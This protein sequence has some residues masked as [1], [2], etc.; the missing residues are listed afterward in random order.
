MLAVLWEVLGDG[1]EDAYQVVR[2]QTPMKV[3]MAEQELQNTCSRESTAEV[4]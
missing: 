4:L 2:E 3:L 1:Q